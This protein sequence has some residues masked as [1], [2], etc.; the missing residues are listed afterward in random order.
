M[1]VKCKKCG[2]IK[3]TGDIFFEDEIFVLAKQGGKG[4]DMAAPIR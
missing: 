4:H 3:K 2:K 1:T